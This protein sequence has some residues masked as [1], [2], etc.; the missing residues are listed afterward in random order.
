MGTRS[1]PAVANQPYFVTA[2][3]NN[4]QPIFRDHEAADLMLTELSR[5]RD[6]LGFALLGYALMPDHIHLIVVPTSA[7]KLS[8]ITQSAKGRFARLWNKRR[9]HQGHIWQPRF[10]ESA[11]RTQEQL[12]Q[13]LEYVDR[14]PVQAGLAQSPEE[15]PYCSA[16]GKLKAD[17]EAYLGGSRTDRAKARPSEGKQPPGR[18]MATGGQVKR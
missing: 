1:H 3:T 2:A 16:G 15:Y 12:G 13:W 18:L 4:R 7:A 11:V 9:G 6:E 17:I 14:N 10:Y 8:Q 5:L